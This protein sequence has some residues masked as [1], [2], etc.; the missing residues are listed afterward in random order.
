MVYEKREIKWCK[1]ILILLLFMRINN[2]THLPS[3]ANINDIEMKL[4]F[5]DKTYPNALQLT[6]GYDSE[7]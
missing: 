7:L 2:E 6:I 1:T 5:K 3:E 4:N